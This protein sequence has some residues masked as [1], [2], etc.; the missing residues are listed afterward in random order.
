[1]T[2]PQARRTTARRPLWDTGWGTKRAAAYAARCARYVSIDRLQLQARGRAAARLDFPYAVG[3]G[4]QRHEAAAAIAIR[5]G[6]DVRRLDRSGRALRIT[7]RPD[8]VARYAAALPRVLDHAEQLASWAAR[9]YSQCARKP[10]HTDHFEGLGARG[11]HAAAYFRAA[12]FR[13]I[14]EVLVG[15]QDIV[16]PEVDLNLPLWE[17][18]ETLGGVLGEYGWVEIRDAYDPDTAQRLLDNADRVKTPASRWP[19]TNK[20]GEQLALF[21]DAHLAPQPISGLVVV[22]PCSRAKTSHPA[23]AGQLYTGS[24]HKHA[25]RTADALT[26]QGGTILVLSA[27]HGLL[28]LDQVIEPYDHTWKDEGSVTVDD[29][30]AQAVDLRLTGADVVLLT[31]SQYTQRAI[32][33]WPNAQTPLAHLGIGRQRGR[34][35]A[36]RESARTRT[37][38]PRETPTAPSLPAAQ[39]SCPMRSP[40]GLRGLHQRARQS[41]SAGPRLPDAAA[42]T[43]PGAHPMTTPH[44]RPVIATEQAEDNEPRCLHE[45]SI[46]PA[47]LTN[48]VAACDR[49]GASVRVGVFT[50]EGCVEYFDCAVAASNHA[51]ELDTDTGENLH[52]WALICPSHDEQPADTCEDCSTMDDTGTEEEELMPDHTET[53]PTPEIG[54]P[55]VE[56]RYYAESETVLAHPEYRED[57]VTITA[58]GST[59]GTSLRLPHAAGHNVHDVLAATGWRLRDRLS[60]V[61]SSNTHRGRVERT[62]PANTPAAQALRTYFT[63][64]AAARRLIADHIAP[65]LNA[66]TRPVVLDGEPFPIG[67]TFRDGYG[68]HATYAAVTRSASLDGL[69]G[70]ISREDAEAA[71]RTACAAPLFTKGDRVVCAD[72]RTRTVEGM[73][74]RPGEPARV[75]VGAG[76]EW[77]AAE[78]TPTPAPLTEEQGRYTVSRNYLSPTDFQPVTDHDGTV[79]AY[80]FQTMESRSDGYGWVRQDGTLAPTTEKR[81]DDLER[82]IRSDHAS[83]TRPPLHSPKA[84]EQDDT[85]LRSL[86]GLISQLRTIARHGDMDEV[87]AALAKHDQDTAE[88]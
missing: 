28:P 5:F 48:P 87:R 45:V 19:V 56:E 20:H 6:L 79:L 47:D 54:E 25:R 26:A 52:R 4:P 32:V 62:T 36:L 34:L 83:K 35:T 60:Y 9:M 80:T 51:A 11:P 13:R 24:L 78:C 68:T 50:E 18:A 70:H 38:T 57:R 46:R 2:T 81:R 42:L 1:M 75:V 77:I 84:T 49:K 63:E 23:A 74:H 55:S 65:N 37:Q 82:L 15:P 40:R 10:Q 88:S 73:T 61:A 12:A 29:L 7:G 27:L 86:R 69:T 14:V 43:S 67:W 44:T 31:P 30:Q 39:A 33:V 85:E 17:Q 71:L 3:R 66:H 22:I 58:A 59:D 16:V 72:G 41:P 53:T 8:A 76:A 21:D 64:E